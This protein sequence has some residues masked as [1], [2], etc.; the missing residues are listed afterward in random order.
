MLMH[1]FVWAVALLTAGALVPGRQLVAESI[2]TLALVLLSC[3]LILST[4]APIL[5]K[6]L[7]GLDK[8]FVIHRLIGL[9]VGVLVITHLEHLRPATDAP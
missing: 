9:T 1:A 5:E 7:E 3:N 4:R 2:S 6:R 8:L